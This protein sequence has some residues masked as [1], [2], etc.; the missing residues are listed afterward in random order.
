MTIDENVECSSLC[1]GQ[2]AWEGGEVCAYIHA[3]FMGR[4]GAKTI[5]HTITAGPLGG[6]LWQTQCARRSNAGAA[7]QQQQL[8]AA[9]L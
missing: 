9:A 4:A 5:P 3:R 6:S 1:R 2:V 7:S 8:R